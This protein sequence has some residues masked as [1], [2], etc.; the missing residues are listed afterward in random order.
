MSARWKHL[1]ERAGLRRAKTKRQALVVPT[2]TLDKFVRQRVRA[3]V[4]LLQM[5]VQG[6]EAEVLRGGAEVLATGEIQRLLIGTHGRARGLPLHEE[7]RELLRA[8]GYTI[9]VDLATPKFQPDG[10]MLARR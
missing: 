3:P 2:L 7:C 5:D 1:L 8:R 9:A 4:D 6:A 10:I